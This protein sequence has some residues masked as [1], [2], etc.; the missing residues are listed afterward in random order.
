MPPFKMTADPNEFDAE[1]RRQQEAAPE[2]RSRP[3]PVQTTTPATPAPQQVTAAPSPVLP[4]VGP[5]TPRTNAPI[6]RP[7]KRAK[8]SPAR[9]ADSP[10]DSS[11]FASPE[12]GRPS[13]STRAKRPNYSETFH[14]L[15]SVLDDSHEPAVQDP[16][17]AAP[18]TIRRKQQQQV[19]A[20]PSP[21]LTLGG[22]PTPWSD[23]PENG[24]AERVT[25]PGA[26]SAEDPL[27][28]TPSTKSRPKKQQ[29][30]ATAAPS[31]AL[32]LVGPPTPRTIAP[33]ERS[34]KRVRFSLADEADSAAPLVDDTPAVAEPTRRSSRFTRATKVN[35]NED[36]HPLDDCVRPGRAPVA[37]ASESGPGEEV[38]G[39][40]AHRHDDQDHHDEKHE[41]AAWDESRE[42]D[43]EEEDDDDFCLE[44]D[45]MP[46][47]DADFL[48]GAEEEIELG[49]EDEEKE[50]EQFR[51]DAALFR[52]IKRDLHMDPPQAFVRG[53]SATDD[54]QRCSE[55]IHELLTAAKAVVS[56]EQSA[57][58]SQWAFAPTLNWVFRYG[59]MDWLL[60][61]IMC[62]LRPGVAEVLG[63]ER[64]TKLD[65]LSLPCGV[66]SVEQ[67]KDSWGIY[68][69][70]VETPGELDGAYIGS[71]TAKDRIFRRIRHYHKRK[72]GVIKMT[73]PSRHWSRAMRPDSKMNLRF[74]WTSTKGFSPAVG[75]IA[76]GLLMVLLRTVRCTLRD[77]TASTNANL[78][79]L[80]NPTIKAF[81]DANGLPNSAIQQFEKLNG[82]CALRQGCNHRGV[83]TYECIRCEQT[84]ARYER[85]MIAYLP[86]G[87]GRM[88]WTCGIRTRVLQQLKSHPGACNMCNRRGLASTCDKGEPCSHCQ[89]TARPGSCNYKFPGAMEDPQSK[90]YH[91]RKNKQNCDPRKLLGAGEAC[92]RCKKENLTCTLTGG[93]IKHRQA[94]EE[95]CIMCAR[96][97]VQCNQK[98][99]N[100]GEACSTCIKRRWTCSNTGAI[101]K[102][103]SHRRHR[104]KHCAKHQ[105]ACDMTQLPRGSSCAECERLGQECVFKPQKCQA[106]KRYQCPCDSSTM[107]GGKC[108]SCIKRGIACSNADAGAD[109]DGGSDHD[110]S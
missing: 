63:R 106:C 5:P 57:D 108:S 27:S 39:R 93:T 107:E 23:R 30:Q 21:A 102:T 98:E 66:Q 19:M 75:L 47:E 9:E 83:A 78:N 28:A 2:P 79:V 65:L 38:M 10:V 32:P 73:E 60:D 51:D 46:P 34:A 69:D 68:L 48:E 87:L 95:K 26:L 61:Q 12:A 43:E 8:P 70:I 109:D 97:G 81:C 96:Q 41:N 25:G 29:Q 110:H 71:G 59:P 7:A 36:Y 14:P 99:V 72:T 100:P 31:S 35:Y 40:N 16:Y 54:E 18:S 85:T 92:N 52:Q 33:T 37:L 55:R 90:C 77:P 64:I 76:E 80:F 24:P 17:P 104:C 53:P 15:N 91:C 86:Q 89:G 1:L 3:R 20:A 84:I 45:Q 56:A 94:K 4:L 105:R 101:P 6:N 42:E 49:G 67:L 44:A 11:A 50:E 62:G 82:A 58:S 88:H 74:L 22:P 103:Q 13:R